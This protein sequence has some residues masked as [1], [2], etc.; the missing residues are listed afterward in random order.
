[1]ISPYYFR[2][3]DG[4]YLFWDGERRPQTHPPVEAM[5]AMG[6]IMD[7]PAVAHTGTHGNADTGI[8]NLIPGV[9]KAGKHGEMAY[10]HQET[11]STFYHPID[12]A[13]RNLGEFLAS[14]GINANPVELINAAI[15]KTNEDHPEDNHLQGFY[16]PEHRK[17]GVSQYQGKDTR[18]DRQHYITHDGNK[19]KITHYTNYHGDDHRLGTFIDSGAIHFGDA[20]REIMQSELGLSEEELGEHK[21]PQ[22][23]MNYLFYPHIKSDWMS[24]G[25]SPSGE[26]YRMGFTDP[27]GHGGRRGASGTNMTIDRLQQAGFPV[28]RL[29]DNMHGVAF[30]DHLPDEFFMQRVGKTRKGEGGT[31]GAVREMLLGASGHPDYIGQALANKTVKQ[32]INFL[33]HPELNDAMIGQVPLSRILASPE[34]R[35]ALLNHLQGYPAFMKLFGRTTGKSF[36]KKLANA[37]TELHTGEE[38][39]N[40]LGLE[41]LRGYIGTA[42]TGKRGSGSHYNMG[43]M[44]AVALLSGI[45]EEAGEGEANSRLRHTPIP[46]ELLDKHGIKL[47]EKSR[48]QAPMI[49]SMISA[50]GKYIADSMGQNTD[51]SVPEELP[52]T[53]IPTGGIRLNVSGQ[54]VP[55]HI[56]YSP[57]N[58]PSYVDTAQPSESAQITQPPVTQAAPAQAAPAQAAPAQAAPAQDTTQMVRPPM[59]SMTPDILAARAK[60]PKLSDEQIQ[61]ILQSPFPERTRPYTPTQVSQYRDTMQV[62]PNTP[63][64]TQLTDY[65]KSEDRLVKAMESLQMREARLD[66][67]VMRKSSSLSIASEHDIS[68]FAKKMGIAPQDIRLIYSAKGDWQRLTKSFGYPE[69]LVKVVKVTFGGE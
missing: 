6:G 14:K 39:E 69:E 48:A 65:M 17:I 45:H 24:Y 40:S 16:S 41:G 50:M 44:G 11:G 22:S 23:P 64:Q 56:P 62:L 47:N 57:L 49:R 38:D 32:T 1:M 5:G 3:S 31:A 51:F 53:A 13:A 61:R 28:E 66:D 7:A 36:H 27:T 54:G 26:E 19:R 30:L 2:K 33:E 35:E 25:T 20:L 59:R 43:N 68:T 67:G 63:V 21:N 60:L 37:V 4:N 10:H 29:F 46:P 42:K 52:T 34:Q 15:A 12:A 9:P 18:R 58:E 8:G 55:E